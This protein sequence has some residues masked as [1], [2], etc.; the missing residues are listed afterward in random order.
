MHL[1]EGLKY[2]IEK[3]LL[4][5]AD[6]P[7]DWPWLIKTLDKPLME[8]DMSVRDLA[9][10]LLGLNQDGS[11]YDTAIPQDFF[12]VACEIVG[13]NIS[14]HVV[15]VYDKGVSGYPV[16]LTQKGRQYLGRL[17]CAGVFAKVE[18]MMSEYTNLKKVTPTSESPPMGKP[19]RYLRIGDSVFDAHD[20]IPYTLDLYDKEQDKMRCF[21]KGETA[22]VTEMFEDGNPTGRV[23]EFIDL[24]LTFATGLNKQSVN[25]IGK[26]LSIVP[27][28][29]S[30]SRILVI[31]GRDHEQ[32]KLVTYTEDETR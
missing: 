14:G 8:D 1:I 7:G 29:G 26:I 15:W 30:G 20:G 19:F 27:R 5:P 32:M 23:T 24:L 13:G 3:K 21:R 31:F 22:S 25:K 28:T 2:L 11:S 6:I 16:A 17:A 9:E 18:K 4:E 10:V 12:T